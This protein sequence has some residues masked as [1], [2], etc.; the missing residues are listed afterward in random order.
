MLLADRTHPPLAGPYVN[1][2]QILNDPLRPVPLVR[3]LPFPRV[4]DTALDQVRG[5][6]SALELSRR[7]NAVDRTAH[8]TRSPAETLGSDR[9]R[10]AFWPLDGGE[11]RHWAPRW[12]DAIQSLKAGAKSAANGAARVA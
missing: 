12:K 9:R 1:M 5:G 6:G 3:R 4:L 7:G 2:L 8:S 11:I 10:L